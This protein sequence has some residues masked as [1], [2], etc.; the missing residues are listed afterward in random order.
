MADQEIIKHIKAAIDASRDKKRNWSSKIREILLEIG[1]IVFAVSLSIWLHGWAEDRKD[2]KEEREFL[3]GL[4][5]DLKADIKEMQGDTAWYGRVKKGMA[6]F[7]RVGA[8]LPLNQDSLVANRWVLFSF[9]QIEPRTSRFEALKS[10][11]RMNIIENKELQ[12]AITDLYT[13]DFP[14]IRRRNEY[15]NSLKDN[16]LMPLV[17]NQIRFDP[18]G[19]ANWQDIFRN[20]AM[21]MMLGAES[22]EN[23][24]LAYVTGINDCGKVIG[25]ID[26]E[27]R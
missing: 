27:L 7:E 26:K 5:E 14:L 15:V 16:R 12:L 19:M 21:R 3:S 18:K 8:G 24:R 25:E 17:F 9:A 23:V 13:K 10:S 20:S 22:L 1:I 6:Y 2:R 11:G 4:R